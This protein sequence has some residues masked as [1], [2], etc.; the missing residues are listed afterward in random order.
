MPSAWNVIEFD[1]IT[2]NGNGTK[3]IQTH[4]AGFRPM[5]MSWEKSESNLKTNDECYRMAQT[6][7]AF[8]RW[9]NMNRDFSYRV[10]YSAG[11]QPGSALNNLLHWNNTGW[12]FGPSAHLEKYFTHS[13][14]SLK[15]ASLSTRSDAFQQDDD[16]NLSYWI[17]ELP[18]EKKWV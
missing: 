13:R 7:V 8:F 14:M 15:S 9:E 5:F 17:L 10:I 16:K 1:S 6:C 2:R 4:F 3:L 11:G 12:R 18:T